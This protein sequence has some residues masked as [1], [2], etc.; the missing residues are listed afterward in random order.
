MKVKC[1]ALYDGTKE[2][3][4]EFANNS[5]KSFLDFEMKNSL[6]RAKKSGRI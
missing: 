1:Y 5:Q 4:S 3:L 6:K 2:I